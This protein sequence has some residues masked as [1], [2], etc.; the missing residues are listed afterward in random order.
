M[1]V[2]YG[3]EGRRSIIGG[4]EE[5]EW[6]GDWDWVGV[7]GIICSGLGTSPTNAYKQRR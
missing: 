1:K 5:W 6:D 2:K 4:S 7:A 3:G